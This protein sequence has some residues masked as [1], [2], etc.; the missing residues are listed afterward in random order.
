MHSAINWISANWELIAGLLYAI[1][2]LANGMTKN[3]EAKSVIG[4]SIDA[5]S[6]LTRAEASGTV[7]LPL[8]LSK[9]VEEEIKNGVHQ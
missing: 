4:K 3:A 1:L 9:K 8:V 2:N 6:V 7:K 5:I